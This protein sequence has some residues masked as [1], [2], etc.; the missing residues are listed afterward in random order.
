MENLLT[1][2]CV[3]VQFSLSCL[4]GSAPN[5]IKAVPIIAAILGSLANI[6]NNKCRGVFPSKSTKLGEQPFSKHNFTIFKFNFDVAKDKFVPCMPPPY[7]ASAPFFI[8][9]LAHLT[10]FSIR[11]KVKGVI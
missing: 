7:F 11:E 5:Y 10:R 2:I 8:K 6:K 4:F 9:I 1:A 3:G